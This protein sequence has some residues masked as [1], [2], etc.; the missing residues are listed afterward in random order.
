MSH[1]TTERSAIMSAV[2][3]VMARIAKHTAGEASERAKKEAAIVEAYDKENKSLRDI[4]EQS[5]LSH[6]GVRKILA[7]AGVPLRGRGRPAKTGP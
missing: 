6:E 2:E 7:K 4:A 5:G 1:E 3:D